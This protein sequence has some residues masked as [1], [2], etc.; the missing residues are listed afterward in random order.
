VANAA[1][2]ATLACFDISVERDCWPPAKRALAPRFNRLI[3]Q[4]RN[5]DYS[6]RHSE[7]AALAERSMIFL[8][9]SY[10]AAKIGASGV[11]SA[12]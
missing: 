12:H 3:D 9:Y 2:D 11:S 10:C 8:P 5:R 4:A 7:R 6:S 1:A